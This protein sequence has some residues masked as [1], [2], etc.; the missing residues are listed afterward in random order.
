MTH[1]SRYMYISGAYWVAKK[2][3]MEEFSLDEN[4]LWGDAED[5]DWSIRVREKYNF[6]MNINSTVH[7]SKQ[8]DRV[9][10]YPNELDVELLKK[11]E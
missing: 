7:L 5:V 2:N 9:F 11:L 6:S 10:G 8:K 4:R 3:I 1:L